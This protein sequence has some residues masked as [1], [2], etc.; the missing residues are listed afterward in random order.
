MLGSPPAF[1]QVYW[2]VKRAAMGASAILYP[3]PPASPPISY[4]HSH[5]PQP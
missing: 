1:A 2:A 3:R 4:S 5:Y